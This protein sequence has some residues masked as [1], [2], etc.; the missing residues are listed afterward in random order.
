ML[1]YNITNN[2]TYYAI[3]QAF[4]K[5]F[6]GSNRIEVGQTLSASSFRLDTN[7]RYQ[8]HV[9]TT[10]GKKYLRACCKTSLI[11][12]TCTDTAYDLRSQIHHFSVTV[13][14]NNRFWNRLLTS[15]NQNSVP[16]SHCMLRSLFLLCLDEKK[17]R[18][19]EGWVLVFFVHPLKAA[20]DDP[21]NKRCELMRECRQVFVNEK[22]AFQGWPCA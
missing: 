22:R 8:A 20:G 15:T 4:H 13:N 11:A 5:S 7:F 6:F 12:N 2:I 17:A 18:L 9:I 21:G 1:A 16:K 14:R 19:N 3:C 10:W